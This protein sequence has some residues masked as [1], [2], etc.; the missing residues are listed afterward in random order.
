MPISI[1]FPKL[2]DVPSEVP[3]FASIRPRWTR[4]AIAHLSR[5]FR[6]EGESRDAG[7]W[8]IVRDQRGVLE[9]YQN[10]HSFR[11]ERLD[12]DGEGRYGTVE[13]LSHEK[14][15]DIASGFVAENAPRG[16]RLGEPVVTEHEVLVAERE[17]SEP[18]RLLAGLQI[19]YRYTIDGFDLMGPGAKTQVT[20]GPDAEIAG[21]YR[22]WREVRPIDSVAT[23]AADAAAE[24]FSASDL[25]ADLDDGGARCEITSVRFGYL[26]RPPTEAQGTLLPA[27]EF[28]GV[29]ST[30]ALQHYEFTNYV[31]G[32][33]L[34]E[35][36]EKWA[37]R[38]GSLSGRLVG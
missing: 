16:A 34:D 33:E 21:A 10:S 27:Y 15:I 36:D 8:T 24:R 13:G 7:A 2:S 18:T 20:I 11:F 12:M 9:I 6:L 37:N 38:V 31:L 14:A 1:D 28:R 22:F 32:C 17:R 19:S 26:T 30:E 25:F 3:L 5:Q 4:E 23:I 29:L 35:G